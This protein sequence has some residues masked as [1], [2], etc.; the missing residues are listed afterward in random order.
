MKRRATVTTA[1]ALAASLALGACSSDSSEPA[2]PTTAPTTEATT[3]TAAAKP[4][5]DQSPPAAV[6]GLT[7]D[8]DTIWLASL[9]SDEVLQ[10]DREDGTIL[11]RF[12]TDG[13]GP[14]D[15]ALGP[16]GTVYVTGFTSGEVGRIADGTYDVL[17]TIEPGINPIELG[18]DGE[19]YVGTFGP[20]GTLYRVPL[21]GGDAEEVATD[22]PDINAF[23]ALPDGTLLAPA[24]GLGGPG[25]AVVIDPGS[26]ETTTIVEGLSPVAAATTDA[27]GNG[28][29][30]ANTTGEVY[31]V[32]VEARTST[33]AATITAGIPFDNLAV[34]DDGTLYLSS[35]TEPTITVVSPDGAAVELAVGTA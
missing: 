5:P 13:A 12:P 25:A 7:I 34:G 23:G 30:L 19:L 32:D 15:V 14:D 10:I 24:G 2:A 27:D 8:G 22:L 29:L 18:S 21:D 6:N 16:D 11:Q 35:F 28:F 20:D 9:D 1:V 26:G 4:H 3:T 33:V 17:T 31:A